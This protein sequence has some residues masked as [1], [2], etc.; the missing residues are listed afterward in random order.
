MGYTS[1]PQPWLQG[2]HA[3]HPRLVKPYVPPRPAEN[4]YAGSARPAPEGVRVL[5]S[6]TWDGQPCERSERVAVTVKTVGEEVV[7][8]VDA[9]FYNDSAPDGPVGPT[10]KLWDHEVVEVFFLGRAERYTEIELSPHGHHLVLQLQGARNI[11][12]KCIPID[13]HVTHHKAGPTLYDRRW[14]G[15]ARIPKDLLPDGPYCWNAYSI[16]GE[17]ADRRFLCLF[18]VPG[19]G[20]FDDEPDFHRLAHFR[21]L[22]LGFESTE[23]GWMGLPYY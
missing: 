13:Y 21:P 20:F 4:N 16:H 22:D 5:I 23:P 1:R 6:N 15:V 8:T 9:P 3:S 18:P 10:D 17:G 2:G 19:P 7:V 11:V 12:R 14:T